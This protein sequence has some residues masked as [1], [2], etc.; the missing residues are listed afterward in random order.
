MIRVPVNPELLRWA[1]HRAGLGRGE[2]PV[3]FKKLPEW[4]AGRLQPTLRQ[5]EGFARKVHVPVGTLLLDEPPEE[6][7]PIPDYR[8]VGSGALPQ[9]SPNLLDTIYLCQER[10]AWYQDYLRSKGAE[11]LDFVGSLT[12]NSDTRAAAEAM[13]DK[14]GITVDGRLKHRTLQKALSA[15]IASAESAGVLV[16][17]SGVVGS[18]TGRKLDPWEFR[19]FALADPLAPLVFVNGRDAKSAQMFTLAHELAHLWLGT[20]SLSNLT[21]PSAPGIRREETWCNAVAAEFLIPLADIERV[22]RLDEPLDE[23]KVRLSRHFKVST[24]VV[25]RRLLDLGRIDRKHFDAS[26]DREVARHESARRSEG[27]DFY[28]TAFVRL[29]KPFARAVIADTLE[30]R[31]R[32][33]DA[34]RMLAVRNPATLDRMASELGLTP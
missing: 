29:S 8:T 30:G 19:G 18:N 14:L 1:R 10:Q 21:S 32:Y 28:R 31:T 12:A 4:E 3:R 16:M 6:P 33:T 20:S 26:W 13:R 2:F 5:L 22:M 25:L 34:F 15:F 11:P 7:V 9:P 17:V 27:G 24:L 23:V